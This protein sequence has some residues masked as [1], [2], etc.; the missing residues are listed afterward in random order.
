M[1]AR[2]LAARTY[3]GDVRVA[4]AAGWGGSCG[5]YFGSGEIV[6]RLGVVDDGIYVEGE[7]PEVCL[8]CC[9]DCLCC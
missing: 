4:T 2:P 8:E 6:G 9:F 3:W 1:E 7:A 5:A